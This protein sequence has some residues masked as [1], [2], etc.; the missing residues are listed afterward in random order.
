MPLLASLASSGPLA[1]PQG[2]KGDERRLCGSESPVGHTCE[3]VRGHDGPHRAQ[4]CLW[5]TP[6]WPKEASL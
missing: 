3:L 6:A 1:G 4:G 2:Q 5:D